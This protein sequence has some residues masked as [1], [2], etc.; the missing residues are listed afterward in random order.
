S[1]D[2]VT[3]TLDQTVGRWNTSFSTHDYEAAYEADANDTSVNVRLVPSDVNDDVW[4]AFFPRPGRQPWLTMGFR[5][6]WQ[7]TDIRD[8][9]WAHQIKPGNC[10][11]SWNFT[12]GSEELTY[13]CGVD[14]F[15]IEAHVDGVTFELL[16]YTLA[17]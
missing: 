16:T 13:F 2:D 12:P 9:L 1:V 14:A 8:Y 15:E 6:L 4:F 17:K 11:V 3:T 5:T 7:D 10:S